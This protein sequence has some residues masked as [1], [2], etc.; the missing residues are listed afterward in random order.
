MKLLVILRNILNGQ[1]LI[2][3]K[4]ESAITLL[5]DITFQIG[6]TG[7][8][9]PV[10]EL[11]PVVISGSTVSRAT[12]HNED[13]ILTKDI[14]I[15]DMVRVH[16]AGEIIPEVIEVDLTQRKNTRTI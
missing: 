1:L 14:R 15:N 6:R 4:A 5:K 10:A 3:F 8:V 13:Y 12:L 11:E 16:K 9:T 2:N 7:V